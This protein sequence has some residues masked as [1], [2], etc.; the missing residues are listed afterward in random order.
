[1]LIECLAHRCDHTA[2]GVC[3]SRQVQCLD[4]RCNALAQPN[5]G[6][7]SGPST[8]GGRLGCLNANPYQVAAGQYDL[9][10]LRRGRS[11]PRFGNSVLFEGTSRA[12]AREDCNS[13]GS[14]P[15]WVRESHQRRHDDAVPRPPGRRTARHYRA[16][17]LPGVDPKVP[18]ENRIGGRTSPGAGR[19]ASPA[20][21]PS[22]HP[23]RP[24][25]SAKN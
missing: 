9:H 16:S 11:P 25:L 21:W 4:G 17:R 18:F 19:H 5:V 7:A 2:N 10:D 14:S 6:R 8:A 20:R 13:A 24:G 1:M 15:R 3:E 23:A 12:F 22:R